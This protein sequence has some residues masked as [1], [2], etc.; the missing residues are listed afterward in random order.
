MT[1]LKGIPRIMPPSLL[2]ILARMGHGDTLV[3][4]DA[5]FPAA[6]VAASTA[7]GLVD[8]CGS[9][10]PA[11]LRAIMALMPLDPTCA[12]VQFMELMPEHKAAGWKTPIK[13][14]YKTIVEE[15]EGRA[16]ECVEV[17]RFKFYDEARKAYAVVSTGETAFYANV[18]LRKG[19]I[20]DSGAK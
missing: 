3:I 13:A 11:I 4:A 10:A 14:T 20:G 6:S 2:H 16:I 19:I 9:D 5:N 17:E 12:P 18:I 7:G 15:A 8:C 1:I